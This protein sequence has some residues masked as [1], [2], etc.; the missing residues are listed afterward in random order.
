MR[1]EGQEDIVLQRL[2]ELEGRAR[3]DLA[4]AD[5][6]LRDAMAEV[7]DNAQVS[8]RHNIA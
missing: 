6:V 5:A 4:R 3:A 2:G 1:S 7:I 8:S